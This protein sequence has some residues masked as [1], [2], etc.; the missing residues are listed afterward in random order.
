MYQQPQKH[1]PQ[2]KLTIG[3]NRQIYAYWGKDTST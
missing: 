1:L 3:R 2:V